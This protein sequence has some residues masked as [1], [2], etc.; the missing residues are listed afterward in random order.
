MKSFKQ[1]FEWGSPNEIRGEYWIQ[2]G[3]VDFADGDVGDRNHE[4]IA[5]DAVMGSYAEEVASLAEELE[6]EHEDIDH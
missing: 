3:Y 5:I 2:D 1:W 4:G 6:V